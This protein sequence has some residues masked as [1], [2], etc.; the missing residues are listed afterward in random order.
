MVDP[1]ASDLLV[2]L[3]RRVHG[4]RESLLNGWPVDRPADR[5]EWVNAAQTE[6]D[7]LHRGYARIEIHTSATWQTQKAIG[8]NQYSNVNKKGSR[9][10]FSPETGVTDESGPD[11]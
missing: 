10:L 3:W 7:A 5:V 2:Q 9:P 4:G 8:V 1:K 11:K 6:A